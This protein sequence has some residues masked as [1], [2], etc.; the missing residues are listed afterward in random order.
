MLV[1]LTK[2]D[3]DKV[4]LSLLK[5]LMNLTNEEVSENSLFD[6]EIYAF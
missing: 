3:A 4:Y 1:F 5:Y 6:E 2:K